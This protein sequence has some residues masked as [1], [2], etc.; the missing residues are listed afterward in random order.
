M[1]PLIVMSPSPEGARIV[2]GS[3]NALELISI[4]PVPS[5]RPIV[6]ALNPSVRAA[7]SVSSTASVPAPP[8]IPVVALAVDG[9]NKS[10]LLPLTELAPPSKSISSAVRVS[11]LAPAATVL[12]AVI[13]DVPAFSTTLPPSV[14]ARLSVM[15]PFVVVISPD[16]VALPVPLCVNV[17]DV[18]MSPAAAVVK[19]PEFVIATAPELANAAFTLTAPALLIVKAPSVLVPPTAPPKVT[20]PVS[21]VIV[22]A[23]SAKFVSKT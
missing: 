14:T 15:A 9:C 21:A 18:V 1:L 22:N 2:T 20:V 8:P 6:M 3:R 23:V 5:E 11:V 4:S 17:L 7:R 13:V 16:I 19:T 12:L 10:V